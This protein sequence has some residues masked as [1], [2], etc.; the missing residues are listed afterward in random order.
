MLVCLFVY[1]ILFVYLFM[2][3]L[4]IA[5]AN[6]S[7]HCSV[8]YCFSWRHKAATCGSLC[9]NL[10]HCDNLKC[11]N[12]CFY[13]YYTFK[14]TNVQISSPVSQG[15]SVLAPKVSKILDLPLVINIV[16]V[17]CICHLVI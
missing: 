15:P 6:T 8:S 12:L 9:N 13:I 2:L 14:L 7:N 1:F 10:T 3:A 16:V 4:Y 17:C 11:E 5:V